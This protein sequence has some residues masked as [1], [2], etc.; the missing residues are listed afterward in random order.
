MI[1][2]ETTHGPGYLTV[3]AE[4]ASKSTASVCTHTRI[5]RI[6]RPDVLSR[7]HASNSSGETRSTCLL[8]PFYFHSQ[9]EKKEEYRSLNGENF[10]FEIFT[11]LSYSL[12]ARAFQLFRPY[13]VCYIKYFEIFTGSLPIDTIGLLFM[14]D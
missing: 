7:D 3:I 8:I 1:T 10:S 13:S 14:R 12:L 4:N 9:M 6:M 5:T 11:V 2:V